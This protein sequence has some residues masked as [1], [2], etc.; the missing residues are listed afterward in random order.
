[1]LYSSASAGFSDGRSKYVFPTTSTASRLA[2]S[3]PASP[4][5]PSARTK[6][7]PWSGPSSADAKSPSQSWLVARPR[8]GLLHLPT[9][10][11]MATNVLVG[12]SVPGLFDGHLDTPVEAPALLG[13]VR[14]HGCAR[15]EPAGRD[16]I[17]TQAGRKQGVGNSLGAVGGQ[18]LILL[19]ERALL[20]ARVAFD[21][22]D[23]LGGVSQQSG[24]H[25]G[26]AA[27][28]V[29]TQV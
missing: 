13:I 29:G 21:G 26:N 18:A 5:M 3:P 7:R 1:M 17:A 12:R 27:L 20:S 6:S 16:A 19:V 2:I 11:L 22:N 9:A 28:S 25:V 8:P 4:P 23:P 10:T 14:G 24:G 15:T